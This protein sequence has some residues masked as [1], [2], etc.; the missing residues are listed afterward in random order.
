M[1][2]TRRA[3]AIVTQARMALHKQSQQARERTFSELRTTHRRADPAA[4]P[5]LAASL[6]GV[7]KPREA[8]VRVTGPRGDG[9]LVV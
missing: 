1:R 6:T 4:P 8:L 3:A 2:V 9:H 5:S 7:E